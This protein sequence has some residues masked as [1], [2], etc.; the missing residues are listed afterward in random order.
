MDRTSPNFLKD[1]ESICL[2]NG[3]L[4]NAYNKGLLTMQETLASIMDNIRNAE[5]ERIEQ[6]QEKTRKI[7]KAKWILQLPKEVQLD[8]RDRC[9]KYL[10][11]EVGEDYIMETEGLS[12][13]AFV[14][15]DVMRQK[16]VDV[17]DSSDTSMEYGLTYE[18][19]KEYI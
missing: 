14:N 12:I 5:I 9:V 19:Y 11:E 2:D 6:E 3:Y 4:I 17:L 8:I 7:T 18:R 1:I 16:V 10:T 13:I 15:A